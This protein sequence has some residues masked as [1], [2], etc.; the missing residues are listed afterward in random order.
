MKK[1]QYIIIS[2]LAL[3]SSCSRSADQM[4]EWTFRAPQTKAS[5]SDD[6]RFSWNA[7]DKISVWNETSGSFVSFTTAAGKGV[8]RATAP[9]DA[10]FSQWAYFPESI[11]KGP[12]KIHVDAGTLPM[13]AKIDE[14]SNLLYFKHA[15]A[16]VTIRLINIPEEA[17]SFVLGSASTG[18]AG[19]FSLTDGVW[20]PGG[21]AGSVTIP[22][23][24][25]NF[26]LTLA[27]PVGEYSLEY[28]VKDASGL[29]ILKRRTEGDFNFQRA[30]SY[31]FPLENMDFENS[32]VIDGNIPIESVLITPD[33]ENWTGLE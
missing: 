23:S 13:C 7:G 32:F 27:V 18:F 21:T 8:F 14:G 9:A 28:S 17:A 11:A 29:D 25:E 30:Y 10:H 33:T 6:G 2:A 1:I 19:D 3:L 5:F 22:L 24:D 15:G 20:L 12:E 26:S 16:L 31:S 4:L